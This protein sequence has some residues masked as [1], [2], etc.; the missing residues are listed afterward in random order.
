[1]RKITVRASFEQGHRLCNE[2][3]ACVKNGKQ[4]SGQDLSGRAFC[5]HWNTRQRKQLFL[6]EIK[7]KGSK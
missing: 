4:E 2:H 5:T 1:M 6:Q 7:S 3:E